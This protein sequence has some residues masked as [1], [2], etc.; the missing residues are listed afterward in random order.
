LLA[1]GATLAQVRD[2]LG[3]S[4]IAVTE[5]YLHTDIEELLTAVQA[6]LG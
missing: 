5:L 4:S 2:I 6:A 1:G 3:H